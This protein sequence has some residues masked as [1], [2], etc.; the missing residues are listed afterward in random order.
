MKRCF[1]LMIILAFIL[2][3]A[4]PVNA[5]ETVVYVKDG[6][7]GNGG[8]PSSPVGTLEAAYARSLEISEIKNECAECKKKDL[9]IDDGTRIPINPRYAAMFRN[10]WFAWEANQDW[11]I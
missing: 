4:V 3:L 11:N 10:K 2:T 6:G 7:T 1:S 5:A 8:S 9:I